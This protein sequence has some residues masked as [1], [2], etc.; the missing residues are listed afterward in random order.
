[1]FF[2][3]LHIL[4]SFW[5]TDRARRRGLD[6][7]IRPQF[8]AI[9]PLTICDIYSNNE[10][11]PM[12]HR[13]AL[14]Q[15]SM[16]LA[17]SLVIGSCAPPGTQS[18]V[19]PA[20]VSRATEHGEVSQDRLGS[21]PISTGSDV[22]LLLP[23]AKAPPA[24]DFK[25]KSFTQRPELQNTVA[26]TLANRSFWGF[27]GYLKLG[28]TTRITG[29]LSSTRECQQ[30]FRV[31]ILTFTSDGETQ[32]PFIRLFGYV[33]DPNAYDGEYIITLR[34]EIG[35]VHVYS[36]LINNGKPQPEPC[37]LLPSPSPS[38]TP[39]GGGGGPT[40]IPSATPTPVPSAT[41]TPTP[42]QSPTPEPE[43]TF[44]PG[45]YSCPPT[46]INQAN[47]IQREIERLRSLIPDAPDSSA[48]VSNDSSGFSTQV[49][50]AVVLAPVIAKLTADYAVALALASVAYVA[51]ELKYN[52]SLELESTVGARL[53]NIESEKKDLLRQ[54]D[55]A[56]TPEQREALQ[57]QFEAKV[58]E[59]NRL[60]HERNQA[61]QTKNQAR[62]KIL[63][64]Q[65][66]NADLQRIGHS[67]E[68]LE[69]QAA[70]F[71]FGDGPSPSGSPLPTPTPVP[72]P[73]IIPTPSSTPSAECPDPDAPNW[74]SEDLK[75][76]MNADRFKRA[77]TVAG[78]DPNP[79]SDT[80][81][82]IRDVDRL[83]RSYGGNASEWYKMKSAVKDRDN[84]SEDTCAPGES[85]QTELFPGGTEYEI[86]WYERRV[87]GQEE[88][89]RLEFKLKSVGESSGD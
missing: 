81:S 22:P 37:P 3:E 14:K 33:P 34:D 12:K 41:P 84:L 13:V 10:G 65:H 23:E 61:L 4:S 87:F 79:N 20:Q 40:P 32:D 86:H 52:E 83:I 27:R 2:T 24:S 21:F 82:R 44:D 28:T 67:I 50:P 11:K 1:M 60:V 54:R 9:D 75:N 70:E 80:G 42:T 53:D 16:F 66:I 73:T 88:P 35:Q 74:S 85:N 62:L 17:L 63:K 56:T 8:K 48:S 72:S 36:V 46:L 78:P 30:V 19:P 76:Q 69:R 68:E 26:G 15:A 77:K 55:E 7:V 49:A 45:E 89:V 51:W 57:Q 39:S 64:L 43:P 58:A 18:P 6:C 5:T 38:P 31:S 59:H 25:V 29:T 71:C 47:A